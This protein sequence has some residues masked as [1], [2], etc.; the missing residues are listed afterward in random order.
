M[1][2]WLYSML[3]LLFF[4]FHLQLCAL[5]DCMKLSYSVDSLRA[6]STVSM[7]SRCCLLPAA[8][9]VVS[10]GTA[11][12][13]SKYHPFF[14]FTSSGSYGAWAWS[15]CPLNNKYPWPNSLVIFCSFLRRVHHW[16]C[17]QGHEQ[18]LASR[19]FLLWYLPGCAR[20]RWICEER[21]K[22][23]SSTTSGS[24]G[25]TCALK[26]G[27]LLVFFSDGGEGESI[28]AVSFELR[29]VQYGLKYLHFSTFF[30]N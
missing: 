22:V 16:P 10:T 23:S 17:D 7:T 14:L 2:L 25:L 15:G 29:K 18:Q 27:P 3:L 13:E 1:F 6:E 24:Q 12:T 28:A 8:T 9:S 30:F 11:V 21:W 4:Y 26:N 5:I 19:L 20:W